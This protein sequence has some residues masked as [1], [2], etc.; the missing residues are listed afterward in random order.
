MAGISN[1]Y[2]DVFKKR[3]ELK[4]SELNLLDKDVSSNSN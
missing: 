1:N 3:R 4:K 2:E